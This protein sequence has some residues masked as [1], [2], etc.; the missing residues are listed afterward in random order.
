MN[1]GGWIHP[2]VMDCFGMLTT[3]DQIHR[4]KEEKFGQNEIL[5]HVV[6]KEV[7]VSRI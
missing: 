2:C 7:T 5:I 6:I 1:K 4:R 3:T